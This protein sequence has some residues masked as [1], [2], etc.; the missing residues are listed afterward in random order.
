MHERAKELVESSLVDFYKEIEAA[1]KSVE[2]VED[3]SKPAKANI[4][5][6]EE[7][8]NGLSIIKNEAGT[9]L[10]API[11]NQEWSMLVGPGLVQYKDWING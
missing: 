3:Y 4:S 6:G 2:L 9:T 8:K 10:K 1:A 5:K 11:N 7:I